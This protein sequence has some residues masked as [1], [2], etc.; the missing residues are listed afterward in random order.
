MRIS[1]FSSLC[2]NKTFING[3]NDVSTSGNKL[4][5]GLKDGKMLEV[6]EVEKGRACGCVCP[7]CNSPLQANK[8]QQRK[9]FSH[10]PRFRTENCENALETA[11]HMMAKQLLSEN[12]LIKLPEL[13]VKETYEHF[14]K[15]TEAEEIVEEATEVALEDVIE[16]DYEFEGF[17]PD[18]SARVNGNK[19]FI[20]IAVTHFVDQTK[21]KKIRDLG[22]PAIEIDLSKAN[23]LISKADLLD[24]V[25]QQ[26]KGKKWISNPKAIGVRQRLRQKLENESQSK[27]LKGQYEF[28]KPKYIPKTSAKKSFE[29]RPESIVPKT[30]GPTRWI[31]CEAC[32][33]LFQKTVDEFPLNVPTIECPDCGFHASGALASTG[34]LPT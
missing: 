34:Q 2:Q 24:L 19:F 6:S 11:I 16:E 31:L 10:D 4:P 8:G 17:R 9:Y 23:R 22:L 20:E 1:S 3:V 18:L 12:K 26:T 27:N 7:N 32:R 5:F 33:H 25:V 13:I 15:K 28:G 21:K 30:S 29:T 14:Y